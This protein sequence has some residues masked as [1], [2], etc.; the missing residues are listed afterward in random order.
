MKKVLF[1]FVIS[2]LI[3]GCQQSKDYS[4]NVQV[5][6][7]QTATFE[8]LAKEDEGLNMTVREQLKGN[9]LYVEC[10]VSNFTFSNRDKKDSGQGYLNLYLN[11]KKIDEIFT[12]AFIIKGLPTGNHK[13]TLELV[14]NNGSS[15]GVKKELE[16]SI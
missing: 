15:Y 6:P 1:V 11:G 12:P 4:S 3:M 10:I 7:D 2:L 16:I 5:I 8:V 13:I 14:H 9:D